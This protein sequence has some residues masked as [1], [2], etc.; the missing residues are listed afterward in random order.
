MNATSSPPILEV[1]NLQIA[2]VSPDGIV[3]AVW[4]TPDELRSCRARHR[5]PLVLQS[6]E[7]YLA[8]RRA[9]L[10]LVHTDASVH[11]PAD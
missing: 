9:P 2:F 3:R 1:E 10:E 4:L 6:L 11:Q 7:D 5:S 8:G